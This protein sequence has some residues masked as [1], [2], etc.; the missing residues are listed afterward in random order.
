MPLD[1]ATEP[2]FGSVGH[3]MSKLMD[4]M[5]KGYYKFSPIETWTPQV[6]LYE[7]ESSY[8]VCVD[9][10]GVVKEEIDLQ[11]HRQSLTL[12]GNRLVPTQPR[13]GAPDANQPKY[14][15]HLMEID[16]GPFV[17]EVELPQDVEADKI[18][19]TYRN[20]MLWIDL[21]KKK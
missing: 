15:V 19:A 7:N 16:H 6:N 2:P 13:E 21:P 8:I 14:R 12:R 5:Q 4:Q 11:V 10:A 17:R 9:L 20:G 1:T 3:Q 18:S